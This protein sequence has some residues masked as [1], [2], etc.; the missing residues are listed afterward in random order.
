[1]GERLGEQERRASV[2]EVVEADVGET[3]LL[4]ERR[5]GTLSE[6]GGVDRGPGL[7]CEDQALIVV[8]VFQGF[9]LLS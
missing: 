2:P 9:Y 6:I 3:D 1:M 4:Q 7:A 5:K 8:G